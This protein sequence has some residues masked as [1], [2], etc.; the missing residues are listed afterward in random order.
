MADESTK[1]YRDRFLT[2]VDDERTRQ[3]EKLG[4]TP[5][6]DVRHEPHEWIG[7]IA[8]YVAQGRWVQAA[9]LCSAAYEA[10]EY[11]RENPPPPEEA[12]RLRP[13]IDCGRVEWSK[14]HTDE[15]HPEYHEYAAS[16]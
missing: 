16:R 12:D 6:H 4:W 13:C 15:D 9:A 14:S 11:R 3:I 10:I 2:A 1:V 5:E 7:L 8:Q